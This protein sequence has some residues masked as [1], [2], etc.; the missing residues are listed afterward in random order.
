MKYMERLQLVMKKTTLLPSSDNPRFESNK[1]T[2]PG[3]HIPAKRH[4]YSGDTTEGNEVWQG[5]AS[6][7]PLR[8]TASLVPLGSSGDF[9]KRGLE[10]PVVGKG[11]LQS[12]KEA[13]LSTLVDPH[14]PQVKNSSR[15]AMTLFR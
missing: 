12:M 8:A 15:N 1:N 9:L 14:C 6:T 7:A 4:E 3:K 2:L 5:A 10:H 13:S 11:F